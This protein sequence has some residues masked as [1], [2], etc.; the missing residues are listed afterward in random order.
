[1]AVSPDRSVPRLRLAPS[2][3]TGP[4]GPPQGGTSSS[5][6]AF[7]VRSGPTPRTWPASNAQLRHEPRCHLHTTD[8]HALVGA[9]LSGEQPTG[10]PAGRGRTYTQRTVPAPGRPRPAPVGPGD[11]AVESG[12]TLGMPSRVHRLRPALSFL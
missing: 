5:S 3:A 10:T 7:P 11:G 6:P 2:D 1:G 8:G 9:H 4:A 12:G